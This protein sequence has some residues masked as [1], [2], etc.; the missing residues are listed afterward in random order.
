MLTVLRAIK[1][2][3]LLLSEKG[4]RFRMILA[5]AL[6][7][8]AFITPMMLGVYIPMAFS[9]RL[10]E[11]PELVGE[12]LRQINV[13]VP[14]SVT[15][16]ETLDR[17][18]TVAAY[19]LTVIFGG[20]ITLPAYACYF[21]YSWQTYSKTRYGFVDIER[22]QKGSYNYFRSLLSGALMLVVPVVCFV[23]LQA[24]YL[25]ARIISENTYGKV[26]DGLGVPMIALLFIF[27]GVSIP[28]CILLLWL[29]NSCFYVPYYYARGYGLVSAYRQSRRLSAEHPFI[30]DGFSLIFGIGA[31]LS[32]PTVGVLLI[33]F[34]LPLAAFTYF[35]LAEHLDGKKLLED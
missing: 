11:L 23:I 18:M 32:I 25:L 2:G 28:L 30:C 34:V 33:L 8:F 9:D 1:D 24:G 4:S 17:L 26:I 20:L 16:S 31:L 19:D 3:W 12:L 7:A 15:T 21:T 13:Q 5:G 10:A 22:P 6:L 29:T 35:S 14:E 27:W